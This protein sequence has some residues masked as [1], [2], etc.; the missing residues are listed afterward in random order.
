MPVS[1]PAGIPA[2]EATSAILARPPGGATTIQR[3][4]WADGDIESLVEAEGIDIEADRLVLIGD[5]NTYGPDIKYLDDR[6]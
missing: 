2:P 5:G 4:A 3:L 6:I 1:T